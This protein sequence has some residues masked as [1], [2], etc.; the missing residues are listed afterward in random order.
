MD[1]A[2]IV[3]SSTRH[4][5]KPDRYGVPIK[6]SRQRVHLAAVRN[7]TSRSTGDTTP[8]TQPMSLSAPSANPGEIMAESQLHY[9]DGD[10]WGRATVP[11][12]ELRVMRRLS[13]FVS[14]LPVVAKADTLTIERLQTVKIAVRRDFEDT[15]LSFTPF[16][17]VTEDHQHGV[18]TA[19]TTTTPPPETRPL[20]VVST[21]PILPYSI[22]LPDR[23]HHGDGVARTGTAA[24]PSHQDYMTQY[25]SAQVAEE[26]TNGGDGLRPIQP[27]QFTRSYRWGVI[28]VLDRSN[29]DFLALR[30]AIL[31]SNVQVRMLFSSTLAMA[32]MKKH[33]S[34]F[35]LGRSTFILRRIRR[36]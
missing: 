13:E 6:L 2:D 18:S 9:D 36:A 15:G 24:R 34:S 5:R 33:C 8:T 10:E 25:Q 26:N 3:P 21:I 19:I 30:E 1:P 14:V 29:S 16:E 4:L 28:D 11:K 32:H 22:M 23:Y 35:V 27:G 20:P 12:A 7:V 31:G 17:S